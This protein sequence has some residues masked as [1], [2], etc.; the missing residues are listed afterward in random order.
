ME[1]GV[2]RLWRREARRL[3]HL[4]SHA[5]QLR[6]DGVAAGARL[7]PPRRGG[8]V[9]RVLLAVDLVKQE[10]EE[11]EKVADG[12]AQAIHEQKCAI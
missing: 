5:P 1:V 9:L 7:P 4:G 3:R 6:R 10:E 8:H 2:L 11:R 12:C